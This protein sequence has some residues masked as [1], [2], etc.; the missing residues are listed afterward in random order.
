MRV[1]PEPPEN[2]LLVPLVE[3]VDGWNRL[4]QFTHRRS[5]SFA[6]SARIMT[7]TGE[8]AFSADALYCGTGHL[9]TFQRLCGRHTIDAVLRSRRQSCVSQRDRNSYAQ[10]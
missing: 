3:D 2:C 10:G 8:G 5:A 1:V 7:S 4:Q 9:D 6:M